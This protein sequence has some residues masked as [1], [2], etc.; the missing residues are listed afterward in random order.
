MRSLMPGGRHGGASEVGDGGD[1][2]AWL[3]WEQRLLSWRPKRLLSE[4]KTGCIKD[5][6]VVGWTRGEL[7]LASLLDAALPIEIRVLG[8]DL[9]RRS[10][11]ALEGVAFR[12][13]TFESASAIGVTPL[14]QPVR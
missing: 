1:G 11:S 10:D 6:G 8:G 4:P 2:D 13:G 7:A 5:N 14:L 12:L 9:K 3:S